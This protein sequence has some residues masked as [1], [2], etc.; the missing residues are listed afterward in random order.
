MIIRNYELGDEQAQVEIYNSVAGRLPAFKVAKVDEV[1]RRYRTTDRDPATKF[2]AVE[3]G[4]VVG[5]AVFSSQGRVSFPWCLPGF[6]HVQPALLDTVTAALRSRGARRAWAAYRADWA[7]VLGFFEAQG[8]SQSRQMINYAADLIRLPHTPVPA[9]ES[10]AP[11]ERAE[12]SALLALD[13]DLFGG[14]DDALL[15]RF[16]WENSFLDPGSLYALRRNRDGSLL[17]VGLVVE[18]AGYADPT[19]IDAAMPCFRLGALGTESERHKRVNGLFSC[20]FTNEGAGD[21]LLGE[22][23]RRLEAAGL[24]S[25]AAQVP[26]DRPALVAFH[27]RHFVRQGA[28]PI[29]SKTLAS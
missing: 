6:E 13:A 11:L 24:A 5:Y 21:V 22:A 3:D 27:D 25:A 4:A 14:E 28:F 9:D 23:V 20:V 10:I 17:G 29:L 2:Y 15:Q 26:S 1:E 16:F 8:F 19:K 18:R 7:P 12:V